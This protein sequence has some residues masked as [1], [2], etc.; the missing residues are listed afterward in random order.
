ML[1]TLHFAVTH[2]GS[3]KQT[4]ICLLRCVWHV[5]MLF[6]I[7]DERFGFLFHQCLATLSKPSIELRVLK[8]FN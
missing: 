5:L 6:V 2:T 1:E 8:Q 7:F 4:A 3:S